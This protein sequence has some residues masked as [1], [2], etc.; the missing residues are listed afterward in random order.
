MLVESTGKVKAVDGL[1][2]SGQGPFNIGNFWNWNE[3]DLM[4]GFDKVLERKMKD[5]VNLNGLKLQNT[6]TWQKTMDQ[7]LS[8]L[9][10]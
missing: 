4:I 5:K 2:F 7:I 6:F 1:F 10:N 8:I 9:C 3:S